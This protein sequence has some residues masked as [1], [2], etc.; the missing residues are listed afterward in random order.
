MLA[1]RFDCAASLQ[2]ER[3]RDR[4]GVRLEA[5]SIDGPTSMIEDPCLLS[6]VSFGTSQSYILPHIATLLV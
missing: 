4:L 1:F 3:Q 5:S 6:R 2:K